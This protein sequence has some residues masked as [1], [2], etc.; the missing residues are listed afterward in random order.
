MNYLTEE[1]FKWQPLETYVKAKKC[2]NK[3]QYTVI[4]RNR[5]APKR[6]IG[7]C[8]DLINKLN[9]TSYE[10]FYYAYFRNAKDNID[11]PIRERGCTP[12]ELETVAYKWMEDTGNPDGYDIST[13]YYGV[14][15]HTIIE[16]YDGWKKEMEVINA[17]H[18][19]GYTTAKTEYREDATLGIDF[20]VFMNDDLKWLVQIKPVTFIFGMKPDLI[21]DRM[22]VFT[23]HDEA[24]KKYPNTPFVYFFYT[25]ENGKIKW[26]YNAKTNRYS[27]KYEDLIDHNGNFKGDKEE[28]LKEQR[29][30]IEL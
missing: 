27:F 26:L 8:Q 24:H 19:K 28:L 23:K 6:S 14:V 18:K 17:F 13:F 22:N 9:P 4:W 30:N 20:K 29:E 1:Q 5:Y 11:L 16:T 25:Q 7:P 15:M 12:E 3:K 2:L 10:D 21:S